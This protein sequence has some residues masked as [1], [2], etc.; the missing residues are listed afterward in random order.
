MSE[1]ASVGKVTS[2]PA[3]DPSSP[4]PDL[5]IAT[6]IFN[7]LGSGLP[8]DVAP[9][10]GEPS[11][12][13]GAPDVCGVQV[14][15]PRDGLLTVIAIADGEEAF[16]D[17]NGNGV[18]DPGEPF[19]D[20]GEPFV[21]QNDS[22]A[23]DPGE[24][25]LDVNGNGKY[26]GPN[27]VWD[28]ATK[29]WTQTVVVYT[30]TPA[31]MPSGVNFLG[32]RWTENTLAGACTPTAAPASFAVKPAQTGPPAVPATSQTYLAFASDQNLNLLDTGTTYGVDVVVG[33]ITVDYLGLKQVADDLGLFY[34]FWPCDQSGF[35]ASQCRSTGPALPCVMT[36]S[37]TGFECGFGGSVIITGGTSAD[38]GTDVVRWNVATPY[39][40][41]GTGKTALG[42]SSLTGTNK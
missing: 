31:T 24:W 38:T 32:T 41:F 23:W 20:Q 7:T 26:D 25:F 13:L 27:G 11:S 29:I 12:D 10:P 30:G 37:I 5:G 21:D 22:G 36:P 40:V 4:A 17:S 18:Y 34:R 28:A 35:C 15:N 19:I 9:N 14:H 16:F 42:G 6:Q 3:Y 2:T 39:S 1:A 33:T 8:F